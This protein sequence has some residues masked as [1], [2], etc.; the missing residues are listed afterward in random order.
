[1]YTDKNDSVVLILQKKM[2]FLHWT[3]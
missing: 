2:Q 3:S 1:M